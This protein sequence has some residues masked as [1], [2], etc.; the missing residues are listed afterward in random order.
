MSSKVFP[1]KLFPA[2]HHIRNISPSS[3][4]ICLCLMN[5]SGSVR[6]GGAGGWLLSRFEYLQLG[7]WRIIFHFSSE[8]VFL[9]SK[10]REE[11][12]R[13][14]FLSLHC[15]L[16][17]QTWDAVKCSR[18][19]RKSVKYPFERI[20]FIKLLVLSCKLPGIEWET[21]SSESDLSLRR[22]LGWLVLRWVFTDYI[23]PDNSSPP[24]L[25]N[26]DC[27]G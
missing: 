9:W 19:S 11:Q 20:I 27:V 10:E 4:S 1:G 5:C 21:N 15:F 17:T 6:R 12:N 14:T 3:N 25:P 16:W 2:K 26:H 23:K 8:N 24:I 7:T 18:V 22:I 13:N